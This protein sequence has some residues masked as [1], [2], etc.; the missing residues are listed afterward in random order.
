MV[1]RNVLSHHAYEGTEE[2]HQNSHWRCTVFGFKF[3]LG[4]PLFCAFHYLFVSLLLYCLLPFFLCFIF[5]SF[6]IRLM[7]GPR[8]SL[9]FRTLR[10]SDHASDMTQA[11]HQ[12]SCADTAGAVID[13]GISSDHHDLR[14]K[15]RK[16]V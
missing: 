2:K 7:H 3:K 12:L 16:C 1:C 9:C 4:C 15:Y 5:S 13:R 10:L 8:T 6:V 14:H 11:F